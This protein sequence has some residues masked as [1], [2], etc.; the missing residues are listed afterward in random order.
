[1]GGES[2]VGKSRL[3]DEVRIRAL[4]KGMVVLHGQYLEN[5]GGLYSAW[6]DIVR[7]LLLSV[8]V[9]DHEALVLKTFIADVERLI[10]RTVSGT[11]A[12]PDE[13][14]I[15]SLLIALLERAKQPTLLLLDDLQWA[16]DSLGILRRLSKVAPQLPLMIVAAYRSDEDQYLYGKLPEMRLIKL[17]RFSTQ[18]VSALCES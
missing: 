16:S 18:E 12:M 1:I 11:A 2:G 10:G 5:V 6:R 17:Q 4:V 13:K 7:R 15:A 8:S 3:L 14:Q 9:D